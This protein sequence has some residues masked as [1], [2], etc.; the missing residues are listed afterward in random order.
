MDDSVR[1]A[2]AKWPNAPAVHG[3]LSLDTGGHW[4]LKDEPIIH[5]GLIDFI[6][7]NYE[8]DSLGRWYFQ[9]GPQRCYVTLEYTPWIL[10][11]DSADTL[12]T[13]TGDVARPGRRAAVD[14]AGNLLIETKRGVGL[15]DPDALP[16]ATDWLLD[17]SGQP[18]TSEAIDRLIAEGRTGGLFLQTGGRSLPLE[19]TRRAEVP[20]EF[21]FDPA[22]A[23]EH[24]P[25]H[26][27]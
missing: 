25:E 24:E 4:W 7:R 22:P 11:L 1:R 12:R 2:M 8:A 21:G 26:P 18:A 14:D 10:H 5:Q 19:W 17:T 13:H 23:E 9:N 16:R 27:Q 3:W 15:L 6:A 20:W